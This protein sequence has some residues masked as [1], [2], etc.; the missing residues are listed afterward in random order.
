LA[1]TIIL[2]HEH[3]DF[4]SV[5]ALC[6]AG[7]L[8]PGATPILPRQVN[9]NIVHFLTVYGA[10]LPLVHADDLPRRRIQRVILVDTQA[11]V[12]VRGMSAQMEVQIIDH[13][14][15]SRELG[16]GWTYSGQEVGA[17]T[18]LL[19]E[20]IIAG[21]PLDLS[22]I[23]ATL[24][25][26]GI[27]EDTGSL[28]YQATTPRDA[29]CVAWLLEHGARLDMANDFLHYPL[30]PDQRALS[31][32]L[33]QNSE[34]HFFAGQQIVIAAVEFPRYVEEVSVL[35][36][37]MRDLFDPAALFLL[38]QFDD[39]VQMIA[40]SS[41]EA[42]NVATIA[43]EMG[44]G[45]HSQASAALIRGVPLSEVKSRLLHLLDTHIQPAVTV[46]QIMSFG[47]RTVEP[48]TTVAQAVEWMQLYGHEGF[49]VIDQ[50]RVVGILS[51]RETDRAMRLGL[52]NA[53]ISMY[54]TKGPIQV[55]PD[56]AVETLQQVMMDSGVGQVPVVSDEGAVLGIV[57]RT[58]LINLLLGSH[59]SKDRGARRQEISSKLEQMMP[60]GKRALLRQAAEAAQS[61]GYPLYIVGGFVRDLLLGRPNLDID[62]VVEGNAIVLARQLAGHAGGRVRSH[63]RFGT[64]K[65]I[66]DNGESLDFVSART[67]FYP[68]PTALPEVES[69]SIKQ[70]L[71]RR[72]FTINT[73]A[74][75]LDG[76]RY[77]ELLDF[78]GGEQDLNDRAIR[79]LHS[80]SLVEDP[81]R[82]LRAIRLEQRLG[83][84][85]EP[86]T[87]E[88]IAN[89]L[90]LLA[91]VSGERIRHELFLLFAEPAP[92]SGLTRMEELDVLR[93]IH[94]GLRCDGWV[95]AKFQT[96]R[97]VMPRWYEQS[98]RPAPVEEEHEALHGVSVP[99]DNAPQ[100]Y[101]SLLAYRL[102]LEEVDTLNARIRLAHDDASLM[103]EGAAL[104]DALVPMQTQ[105]MSPSQVVYLLS[106]FSGPAILVNWVACDSARVREQLS[107]YWEEY[108]LVR[109]VLTGDNLRAMGLPPG[110]VYGRILEAL[111]DA[112]LDGRIS[113]EEEE[114]QIAE[115]WASRVQGRARGR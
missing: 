86:R 16:P 5:A 95:Q 32:L 54:M 77:G 87:Q 25:L 75:R 6:A 49:P 109:P 55:R 108:R 44:G 105:D 114:R 78:Y 46:R 80:L 33:M 28:S 69:S 43:A 97:Q 37:R 84:H 41:N 89:A 38:V 96:L 90:G 81:T 99:G 50:G 110:P 106:P 36:H 14:P 8:Y 72:D 85:I 31:E 51:R 27:Y 26:M 57:T 76:E 104:R 24:F 82:I 39:Q 59:S 29:H 94:P 52:G 112:R 4:D 34:N 22:P 9:R 13:H 113:S 61:L 107:R 47:V 111:R 102:I 21:Q 58:D 98:W 115:E 88:L 45:G 20:R 19:V 83:F 3:A 65:W 71:H 1:I 2:T 67:E 68:H 100:L 48:T 101:L 60:E 30:T 11:M 103:R 15:L 17:T 12:T 91:R 79:V 7:R 40:R 70:D 10:E 62:L 53:A 64:A 42:I 63:A 18:T 92:E 66:L 23:E 74:I 56:D 73:L 93:Q 35:A